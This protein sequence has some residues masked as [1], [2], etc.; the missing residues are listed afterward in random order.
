M[1]QINRRNLFKVLGLTAGGIFIPEPVKV[2]SFVGG[3]AY[4]W[5]DDVP[6]GTMKRFD[7]LYPV[8]NT[9][10]FLKWKR[11]SCFTITDHLGNEVELVSKACQNRLYGTYRTPK[12]A[13][14]LART[15]RMFA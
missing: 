6:D 9:D 3:W 7:Y 14:T 1:S 15:I 12:E 10:L 2:Y 5:L 8:R 13:M 4:E 11:I